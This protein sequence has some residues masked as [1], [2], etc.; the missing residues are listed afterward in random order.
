[1]VVFDVF[2]G[3]PDDLLSLLPWEQYLWKRKL[4]NGA[5]IDQL[6]VFAWR[7]SKKRTLNV[8]LLFLS[9]LA[10]GLRLAWCFEKFKIDEVGSSTLIKVVDGMMVRVWE[11]SGR[12]PTNKISGH[13]RSAAVELQSPAL[14]S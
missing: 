14:Q 9:C 2:D 3:S 4:C 7:V 6:R 8:L 13:R 12:R 11:R 5:C 10:G 1:M